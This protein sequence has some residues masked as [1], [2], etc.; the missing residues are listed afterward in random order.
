MV[1]DGAGNA[2][3]FCYPIL[4]Y[5]EIKLKPQ[6]MYEAKR[7]RPFTR[8]YTVIWGSFVKAQL[9]CR[10]EAA[11]AHGMARSYRNRDSRVVFRLD[12][13]SRRYI[14]IYSMFQISQNLGIRYMNAYMY[15]CV[16]IMCVFN[17]MHVEM[18]S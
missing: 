18:R 9:Y 1:A 2:P 15:I 4:T 8:F 11:W 13:I 5:R 12:T 10:R 6:A 7:S 3:I 17:Y 14:I 16:G